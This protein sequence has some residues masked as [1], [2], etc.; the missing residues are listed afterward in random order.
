VPVVPVEVALKSKKFLFSLCY[1]YGLLNRLKGDLQDYEKDKNALL[2]F[3][4]GVRIK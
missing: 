2:V 4:V 1:E 3:E